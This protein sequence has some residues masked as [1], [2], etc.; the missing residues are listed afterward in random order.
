LGYS[1]Y[2]QKNTKKEGQ[3]GLGA[4]PKAFWAIPVLFRSLN[5]GKS[6]ESWQTG[7]QD[8]FWRRLPHNTGKVDL[9]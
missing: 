4:V 1:Q 6:I 3:A 2:C 7:T 8:S 5:K 9:I